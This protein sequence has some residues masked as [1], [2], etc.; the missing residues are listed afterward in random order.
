[1]IFDQSPSA[2]SSHSETLKLS[3]IG[4]KRQR[5]QQNQIFPLIEQDRIEQNRTERINHGFDTQH[6]Q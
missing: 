1:M 4:T 6:H 5:E 3:T 2:Q